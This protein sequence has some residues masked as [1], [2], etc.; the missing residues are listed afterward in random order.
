MDNHFF[1]KKETEYIKSQPVKNC[2]S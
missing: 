2:Y 1:S